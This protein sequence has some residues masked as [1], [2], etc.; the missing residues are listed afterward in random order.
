M[1]HWDF[2]RDRFPN[3]FSGITTGILCTVVFAGV[4][5]LRGT[6][7]LAG[8]INTFAGQGTIVY[9]F[10]ILCIMAAF[11]V[12]PIRPFVFIRGLIVN[13]Y[14]ALLFAASFV[15]SLAATW[16]IIGL[17]PSLNAGEA[18]INMAIIAAMTF[19]VLTIIVLSL[20]PAQFLIYYK[21]SSW[22]GLTFF[23]FTSLF[24]GII[25]GWLAFI[26]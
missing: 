23:F 6:S 5:F 19:A 9:L 8:A 4:D 1:S 15:L 12:I 7:I 2:V 14:D 3:I 24:V 22:K 20:S 18:A 21:K 17:I 26:S 25:C 11:S 16:V 10:S 13:I